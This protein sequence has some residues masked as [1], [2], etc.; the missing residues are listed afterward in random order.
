MH[1]YIA[2]GYIG[3]K[4]YQRGWRVC[5]V[6]ASRVAAHGPVVDVELLDG[7]VI[8]DCSASAVKERK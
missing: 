3:G 2:A 1:V 4:R 6:L 7:T 5:R 8:T